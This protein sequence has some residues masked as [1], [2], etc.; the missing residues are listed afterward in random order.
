MRQRVL[1][2]VLMLVVGVAPVPVVAQASQG[3][4]PSGGEQVPKAQPASGEFVFSGHGFGHGIGMSQYGARGAARLGCDARTILETYFP[5]AQ[6][7]QAPM[8][9]GVVVGLAQY[10]RTMDVEA[11]GEPVRWELCASGTAC[12]TVPVT[13]SGGATWTVAVRPDASYE[14]SQGGEVLWAGGDKERILR[15]TLSQAD[16]DDRVVLL[17]FTGARYKWGLLEIDSVLADPTTMAVTIDI[18]SVE[19]Y[20]R[21]VAEMPETWPTE[22]LRAQAIAARSFAVARIQPTAL[23]RP[24][25]CHLY[26]TMRDQVYRGY[27]KEFADAS[28]GSGWVE[29]VDAT[30]GQTIRYQ[31]RTVTAFYAS[32][33]GGHSESGLFTFGVDIPYLE[34]IDDSRWDLASDN[35]HR[36]WS[37]GISADKL[38]AVAGVGRATRIELPDPRGALGRVGDPARGHGGVRIEGTAGTVTMS[39]ASLQSAL[40]LRSTAFAVQPPEEPKVGEPPG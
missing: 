6:V 4:L 28:A 35:P 10:A 13:Q 38:G 19:R 16:S 5:G 17:P 15:A 9:P 30:A 20:L 12:E 18:P 36:S 39:G 26:A 7:G 24:C 29:A 21:G 14:I 22:A 11:V 34:P 40:G 33:H 3:C 37:V 2:L 27:S 32:S 23:Q 25:R 1:I 31:D 8:P